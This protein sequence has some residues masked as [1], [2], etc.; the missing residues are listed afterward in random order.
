MSNNNNDNGALIGVAFLIAALGFVAIAMYAIACFVAFALTLLSILA[1]NRPIRLFG[2]TLCTPLEARI[3]IGSGMAGAIAVPVFALFC[4]AIFD[5]RIDDD[6]WFYLITGGYSLGSLMIMTQLAKAYPDGL[7][8]EAEGPT[9]GHIPEPPR[10]PAP[11]PAPFQYASWDDEVGPESQRPECAGCAM[12]TGRDP[13][14]PVYR[15]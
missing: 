1:W 3:F 12:M 15:R 14:A 11:P 5:L 6:W 9:I 7:P 13:S 4:S 10:L 2:E 8:S